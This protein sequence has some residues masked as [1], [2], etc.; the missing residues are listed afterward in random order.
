[1]GQSQEYVGSICQVAVELIIGQAAL[2]RTAVGPFFAMAH[3]RILIFV[4][5][6]EWWSSEYNIEKTMIIMI[7]QQN[8]DK[9][10]MSSG[11]SRFMIIS[12]LVEANIC[13]KKPNHS[14]KN[15]GL[16]WHFF[17]LLTHKI[18]ENPLNPPFFTVNPPFVGQMCWSS[19]CILQRDARQGGAVAQL[20]ASAMELLESEEWEDPSRARR[21]HR[22]GEHFTE[23][24]WGNSGIHHDLPMIY[25]ASPWFIMIDPWFTRDLRWFIHD[26]PVIY[27]DLPMIYPWFTRDLPTFANTEMGCSHQKIWGSGCFQEAK[28]IRRLT[29]TIWFDMGW[30]PNSNS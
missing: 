9:D 1:M 28:C 11:S 2:D 17:L 30:L 22:G 13:R 16:L 21:W 6:N 18:Q 19:P 14:G 3:G 12:D 4:D 8:K 24:I 5:D 26:L 7:Y 25:H 15:H 27:H 10:H 20:R 23:K 29:P